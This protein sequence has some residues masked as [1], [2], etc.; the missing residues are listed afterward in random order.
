[1]HLGALLKFMKSERL[2]PRPSAP[3]MLHSFDGIAA[4]VFNFKT[5]KCP[6]QL[7]SDPACRRARAIIQRVQDEA[8]RAKQNLQ[9]LDLEEYP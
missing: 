5:L 9:G 6:D 1:M 4:A 2:D 7:S 8:T 3:F